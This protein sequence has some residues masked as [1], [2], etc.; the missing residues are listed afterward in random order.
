MLTEYAN[1]TVKK[2]VAKYGLYLLTKVTSNQKM[3]MAK[4]LNLMQ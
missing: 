3:R 2:K 4:F 1:M